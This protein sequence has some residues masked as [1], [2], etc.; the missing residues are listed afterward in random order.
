[1]IPYRAYKRTDAQNQALHM[2]LLQYTVIEGQG[3]DKW[4]EWAKAGDWHQPVICTV[5]DINDAMDYM[6][7]MYWSYPNYGEE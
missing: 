1:M 4:L 5:D 2:V 3:P 6:T 7:E